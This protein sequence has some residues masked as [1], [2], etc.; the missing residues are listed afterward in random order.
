MLIETNLIHLV[1]G[2]EQSRRRPVIAGLAMDLINITRK[3][4]I[5]LGKAKDAE[6]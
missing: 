3:C 5:I 2:R 1:E 4:S 6:S